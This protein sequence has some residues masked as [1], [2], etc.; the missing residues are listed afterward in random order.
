M[1]NVQSSPTEAKF[2]RVR[3]TNPKIG[4]TLAGEAAIVAL[5]LAGLRVI[6]MANHHLL[7][8]LLVR[9]PSTPS[10]VGHQTAPPVT[11]DES[12]LPSQLT[13]TGCAYIYACTSYLTN[14]S[15]LHDELVAGMPVVGISMHKWRISPN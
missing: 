14:G 1:G 8:A 12:I 9:S 2:R 11:V 5:Q 15:R 10:R 13:L 7:P 6:T 4:A 3:L